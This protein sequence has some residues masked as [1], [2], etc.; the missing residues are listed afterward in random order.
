ML[1]K[2]L[3]IGFM[4]AII[5]SLGSSFYFLV[6][7]KGEG[8]RTVRRLTWRVGLSLALVIA[9]YVGFRMGWIEPQGVNP[10]QYPAAEGGSD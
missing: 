9:L 10:V 1:S 5:Y 4:L 6:R 8:D 3:I 7:D 2:I